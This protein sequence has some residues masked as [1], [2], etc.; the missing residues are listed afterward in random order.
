[1]MSYFR[2]RPAVTILAITECRGLVQ[3]GTIPLSAKLRPNWRCT[4]STKAWYFSC[5]FT[6]LRNASMMKKVN[7]SDIMSPKV[8][9]HSGAPDGA[10]SSSVTILRRHFGQADPGR[11]EGV[12]LLLDH[13]RVLTGL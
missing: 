5:S 8:R 13:P 6:S 1:M 7:N 3:P 10:S 4:D 2:A 11:Q 12:Q 9:A